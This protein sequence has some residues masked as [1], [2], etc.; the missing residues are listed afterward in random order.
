MVLWKAHHGRC[1]VCNQPFTDETGWHIHH[2]IWRSHGGPD[3][4][5]NRVLLASHLSS[6]CACSPI[7]QGT[8]ASHHG[9]FGWLERYAVKVGRLLNAV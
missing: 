1:L 3:T 9:T 5:E 6:Q 4:A 8:T 2:I 7:I